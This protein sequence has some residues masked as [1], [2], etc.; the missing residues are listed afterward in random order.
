MTIWSTVSAIARFAGFIDSE[1]VLVIIKHSFHL[2]DSYFRIATMPL[3]S[4]LGMFLWLASTA[5][6]L[7]SRSP[8]VNAWT[9][10]KGRTAATITG[11]VR[12][13]AK[14]PVANVEVT[15]RPGAHRSRTDS[16][17]R[18]TI[19]GLEAGR[20]VVV[21]RKLGY[22]PVTW[23]VNLGLD[24]RVDVQLSFDRTL[25]QLDTVV[26]SADGSCSR[27]SVD[28]FVC[29]RRSAGSRGV[30]MDYN[31]ID[32]KAPIY[33]ADLLNDIDA[34]RVDTRSSPSGTIR[35]ASPA[36][37]GGCLTSV[38]DGRRVSLTELIPQ[39][40]WDLVAIEIYA[41]PDSVPEEYREF[42]A[43]TTT[44]QMRQCSVVV[45]WTTKAPLLPKT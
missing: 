41:Q 17:G 23:E 16:A 20:Y 7:V 24:G 5:S 14:R 42:T 13:T 29:R 36:R 35:V 40:P 21:A 15:A 33:T 32:D 44:S 25:P 30:F 12:D 2:A 39:R 3:K 37:R 27:R 6:A 22:A 11:I 28:G 45:Y 26:V 31:D 4:R 18:F 19:G 38:I 9:V 10:S 34:F 8:N 43:R 1:R